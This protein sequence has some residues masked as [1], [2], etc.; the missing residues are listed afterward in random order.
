MKK[1][2]YAYRTAVAAIAVISYVY[3][4]GVIGKLAYDLCSEAGKK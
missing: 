3:S 1:L 2:K 4:V